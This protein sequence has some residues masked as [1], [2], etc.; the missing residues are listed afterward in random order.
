M[1]TLITCLTFSFLLAFS[2]NSKAQTFSF[3]NILNCD[4]TISYEEWDGNSCTNC[5]FNTV[6]ISPGTSHVITLC[7]AT[8]YDICVNIISIGGSSVPSNHATLF[9]CHMIAST[10]QSGTLPTSCGG[11]IWSVNHAGANWSIQ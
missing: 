4:V 11:G 7:N 2:T 1:K 9:N 3:D 8:N 5:S 10:G 6:T